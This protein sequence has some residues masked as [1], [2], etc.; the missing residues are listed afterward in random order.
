MVTVGGCGEGLER[1]EGGRGEEGARR[2]GGE[3]CGRE[4]G[5]SGRGERRVGRGRGCGAGAGRWRD[6]SEGRG[7][8]FGGRRGGGS[9]GRSFGAE[10]GGGGVGGEGEAHGGGFALLSLSAP[11]L[12]RACC[13]LAGRVLCA[14]STTHVA[15]SDA[16][17]STRN[18]E[19]F[20]NVNGVERVTV[21]GG[22]RCCKHLANPPQKKRWLRGTGPQRR[23]G[24]R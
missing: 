21:R 11:L 13:G 8:R 17:D 7:R 19:S 15:S 5:E 24:K 20:G 16:E 18:L 9:D 12:L 14:C 10:R 3:G 23:T 22:Q 2:G 4:D 1:E 6:A